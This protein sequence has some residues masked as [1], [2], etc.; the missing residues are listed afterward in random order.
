MLDC[1]MAEGGTN[2]NWRSPAFR[3]EIRKKIA[4][5][6]L[7][8]P[9]QIL[10]AIYMEEQIFNRSH[11]AD[12][13]L[14]FLDKLLEV[15]HAKRMENQ[16]QGQR[17]PVGQGGPGIQPGIVA[18]G[19]GPSPGPTQQRQRRH[20]YLILAFREDVRNKIANALRGLRDTRPHPPPHP[21]VDIE[22]QIFNMS[23]SFDEYG[24]HV[25]KILRLL[26]ARRMGNQGQGPR[27]PL[28]QGSS[29]VQP[30]I[31]G[32]GLGPSARPTQQIQR[33]DL[34]LI[35]DSNIAESRLNP[36]WRSPAFR[37]EMR[38]RIANIMRGLRNPWRPPVYLEEQIFL[39]SH[40]AGEYCN[41]VAHILRFL[42]AKIIANQ[43]PSQS[44]GLKTF[45]IFHE[46][47]C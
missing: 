4:T 39:R 43:V 24:N 2:Q 44:C 47:S 20:V 14:K 16:G 12:D 35:R 27:G 6:G 40:S 13:Y 45:S 8:D 28:G 38:N 9:C 30:G 19:Q 36:D 15:L 31:V 42:Q 26:H 23:Y 29:G 3:E 1:S 41:F 7:G 37:E 22:E 18:P 5:H 25:N 33:S 34:Q 11:S 32:P 17:D 46:R 10:P 21:H